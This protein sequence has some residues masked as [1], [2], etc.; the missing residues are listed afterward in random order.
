MDEFHMTLIFLGKYRDFNS[1]QTAELSSPVKKRK[2]EESSE[3]GEEKR[4]KVLDD[5]DVDKTEENRHELNT[6][7]A[8]TKRCEPRQCYRLVRLISCVLL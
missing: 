2:R 8:T 6:K 4:H 5:R 3:V 1:W 7:R